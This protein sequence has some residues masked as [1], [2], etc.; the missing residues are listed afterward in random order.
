MC[1]AFAY[2]LPASQGRQRRR[3]KRETGLDGTHVFPGASRCLTLP[4]TLAAVIG[5]AF[6][7]FRLEMYADC[8]GRR[9]KEAELLAYGRA[10]MHAIQSFYKAVPGEGARYPKSVEELISD[11][12]LPGRHYL[13]RL[14]KDPITGGNFELVRN[15]ASGIVGV[16]SA[17]RAAPFRKRGFDKELAGFEKAATYRDWLFDA[18]K[19]L[20]PPLAKGTVQAAALPPAPAKTAFASR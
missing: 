11:P 9:D 4:L 13:R 12:R 10:Y 7:V 15:D 1:A 20:P 2:S 5:L 6:A 16:V 19:A 14:Y 8:F 17:S 18:S 3:K